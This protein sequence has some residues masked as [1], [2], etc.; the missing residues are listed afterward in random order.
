MLLN[1][2]FWPL[3]WA[4]VFR[5]RLVR[6]IGLAHIAAVILGAVFGSGLQ[7]VPVSYSLGVL[8]VTNFFVSLMGWDMSENIIADNHDE[9]RIWELTCVFHSLVVGGMIGVSLFP[10]A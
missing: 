2:I 4:K 1:S 6:P 9:V 5:H 7:G 8:Y 3:L 10:H